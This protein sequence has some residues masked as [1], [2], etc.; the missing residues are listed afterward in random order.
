[1]S[2]CLYLLYHLTMDLFGRAPALAPRAA[3][4]GALPC[5]AAPRAPR[6]FRRGGGA[7]ISWLHPAPPSF[8]YCC[9]RVAPAAAA[10][11]NDKREEAAEGQR[12][13]A[14][15]KRGE[16]KRAAKHLG[17]SS[18]PSIR[19]AVHQ[20]TPPESTEVAPPE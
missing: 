17:F 1:M 3:P 2:M 7:T 12:R 5:G 20:F 4:G 9:P 11:A 8:S 16:E 6:G 14:R 15:E 13:R 19:A 18:T 10:A